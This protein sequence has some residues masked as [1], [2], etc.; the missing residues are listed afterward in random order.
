MTRLS[1]GGTTPR[2]PRSTPDEKAI[3]SG[4]RTPGETTSLPARSTPHE[5]ARVSGMA[6]ARAVPF[7]CPYCGEE[8]L[9]PQGAADGEWHCR[10]CTRSFQLR[11]AGMGAVL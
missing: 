8:D 11:F 3:I 7:Y 6:S 2:T 9:E 10:S 4:M 5:N 1:P